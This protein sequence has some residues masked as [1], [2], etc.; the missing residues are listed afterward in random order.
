MNTNITNFL[1]NSVLF[2]L[3][4]TLNQIYFRYKY[5]ALNQLRVKMKVS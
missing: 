2:I 3:Y 5:K 4:K 1:R